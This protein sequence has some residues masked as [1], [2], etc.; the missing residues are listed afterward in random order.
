VP[1]IEVPRQK[2]VVFPV[3]TT[4]F[5]IGV[6]DGTS[7]KPKL[8]RTLASVVAPEI[9][10]QASRSGMVVLRR[11]MLAAFGLDRASTVK[12]LAKW[13]TTAA[14]EI[15]ARQRG[16]RYVDRESVG[17]W[18]S[19]RNYSALRSALGVDF[20]LFVVI[21]DLR[22][23]AGQAVANA[24]G[25]TYTYFKQFGV[26]CV[27]ELDDGRMIACT[28]QADF[29]GNLSDPAVAIWLV[30]RLF[31]DLG[32]L[33]DTVWP[34]YCGSRMNLSLQLPSESVSSVAVHGTR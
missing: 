15:A 10:R 7:S 5:E 34:Q 11:E 23:T 19:S 24:I 28:S 14:F 22:E 21:R 31:Y 17:E 3:K 2:I 6:W 32:R 20:A 18:R 16:G 27:A 8:A 26:A 25:G 30:Q 1:Y 12:H 4:A 29:R 33:L 9:E 13:G